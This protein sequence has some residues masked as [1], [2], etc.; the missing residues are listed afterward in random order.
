MNI[1][2]IFF[3]LISVT[4][5]SCKKEPGEGGFASIEGKVYVKNYDASYTIL[6]AEY[7]LP[8]ETVYIIYGNDKEVGN[9]V[10]TSY[11]GSFKFNYLRKGKYKVYV[12]GEDPTKPYLSF[13]KEELMEI[14]ITKKKEKVVLN[15]LVIIK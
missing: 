13:P 15:D 7:Y 9:T 5:F 3:I 10:K 8:G 6:T 11:D 1:K 2:I 14:T 12:I 4:F